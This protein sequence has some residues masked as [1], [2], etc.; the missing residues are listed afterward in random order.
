MNV[1]YKIL[2][3]VAMG[4]LL[5]YSGFRMGIERNE[6]QRTKRTVA[7]LTERNDQLQTVRTRVLAVPRAGNACWLCKNYAA[8]DD[9]DAVSANAAVQCVSANGQ[10]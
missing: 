1:V 4:I 3:F 5:W 9:A 7:E 8:A 2:I 6:N 10:P